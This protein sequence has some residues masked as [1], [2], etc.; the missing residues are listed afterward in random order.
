LPAPRSSAC[1]ATV[2]L[3]LQVTGAGAKSWVFRYWV[4]ERDPVTGELVRNPATKKVCGISREMGLGSFTVVTLDEAREAAADVRRLRYQGID[5]IEAR[6]EAKQT[7]A[8]EKAKALK[9]KDAATAYIAAHRAGWKNKKHAEQW[10]ATLET[11][12]YPD[13]G[14]VSVQAIDTALVMKVIEPIWSTKSET[15]GRLRGR[16]ESVLDWATVRGYRKGENPARWRGHLDHLLPARSKVRKVEHHPA[17][18]YG[19]LPAFLE[20]LRKQEGVAAMALEFTILTAARAFD[21]K[22]ESMMADS[23]D[24]ANEIQHPHWDKGPAMNGEALFRRSART[25]HCGNRGRSYPRGSC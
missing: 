6:R 12:A 8:L 5:P 4:P 9:F 19:E 16:I 2:A 10:T 24:G 25:G 14:D 13:I 21:G 3:Y 23:Q 1:T 11:Y 7:A 15:T 17:L 20:A 22:V 18:P